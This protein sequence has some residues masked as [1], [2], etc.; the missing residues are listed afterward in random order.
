VLTPRLAPPF[1]CVHPAFTPRFPLQWEYLYDCLR[2]AELAR[3]AGALPHGDAM[4]LQRRDW[5]VAR[6]AARQAVRLCDRGLHG[7]MAALA[8]RFG[9]RAPPPPLPS[10]TQWTRLVLRPVLNGHVSSP[11]VR[12]PRAQRSGAGA[13]GDQN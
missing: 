9:V 11:P 5:K 12:V 7:E 13:Q 10:R 4:R 8:D 3:A 2:H 6:R 1:R